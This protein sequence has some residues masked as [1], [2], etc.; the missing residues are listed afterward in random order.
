MAWK[1]MEL[2]PSALQKEGWERKISLDIYLPLEGFP[3]LYRDGLLW[4][5]LILHKDWVIKKSSQIH[6]SLKYCAIVNL[7]LGSDII[8]K[9]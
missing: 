3:Q 8:L 6:K 9:W 1:H 4:Y 5:I 2:A 7:R